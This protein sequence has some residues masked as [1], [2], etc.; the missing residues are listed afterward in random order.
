MTNVCKGGTRES[1]KVR[2]A[3]YQS[4]N[5]LKLKDHYLIL[6]VKIRLRTANEARGL[7]L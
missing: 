6:S 5:V 1:R 7:I 3:Q 4:G 2:D